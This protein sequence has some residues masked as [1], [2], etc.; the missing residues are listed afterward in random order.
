MHTYRDLPLLKLLLRFF[1]H[2]CATYCIPLA[3]R[4][5]YLVSK[6]KITYFLSF[7][8]KYNDENYTTSMHI[9]LHNPTHHSATDYAICF[10]RELHNLYHFLSAGKI[11]NNSIP[12][13]FKNQFG[14]RKWWKNTILRYRLSFNFYPHRCGRSSLFP[15]ICPNVFPSK[16]H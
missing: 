2:A 15:R 4:K 8:F 5:N 14:G 9:H 16:S 6:F 7:F 3:H 10:T 11:I 12:R 1:T 13:F